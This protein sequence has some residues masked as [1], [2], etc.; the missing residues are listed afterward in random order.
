MAE[1]ADD[2]ITRQALGRAAFLGDLYDAK[3]DRFCGINLFKATPRSSAIKKQDNPHSNISITASG[4]TDEKLN[5]LDVN[6]DLKLSVLAGMVQL[7]GA[8]KYLIDKK[9]SFKSVESALVCKITTV[10]EKLDIL[11]DDLKACISKA[12]LKHPTATHVVVQIDWGANCTIRVTDRNS[13]NKKKKEVKGLLN[14]FVKKLQWIVSA[15]VEGELGLTEDDR[16]SW[17][18][19]SLK[20]FGDVLPEEL[21]TTVDGTMEMMRNL[22]KLIQKSNDG[23]GKPLEYVMFPLSSPS[24]RNNLLINITKNRAIQKIDEGQIVRSIQIYD[25]MLEF[26]QKAHDQEEEMTDESDRKEARSIAER[27]EVQEGSFRS[28]L[29]KV[30]I[31]LRSGN[32]D[33]NAIPDLCSCI[34]A[35]ETFERCEKMFKFTEEKKGQP[36]HED[37]TKERAAKDMA[38]CEGDYQYSLLALNKCCTQMFYVGKTGDILF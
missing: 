38:Q 30:V 34:E 18:N 24:F 2:T 15:K 5:T 32:C 4:S 29:Q 33:S 37:L 12:A 10:V 8:A 16:K 22:S 1:N 35:N 11:R 26:I 17:E 3:T 20:I 13:N 31:A 6:G 14:S 7:G 36:H 9:D 19:F 23:K 21:P 27:L 28:N 25:R